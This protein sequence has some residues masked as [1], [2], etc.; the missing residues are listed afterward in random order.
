MPQYDPVIDVNGVPRT[1]RQF[2]CRLEPGLD[3]EDNV[4]FYAG[5]PDYLSHQPKAE[6]PESHHPHKAAE[7]KWFMGIDDV[8]PGCEECHATPDEVIEG[9]L[10]ECQSCNAILCL[11]CHHEHFIDHGI[12][13]Y[14]DEEQ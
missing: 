3:F 8:R 2:D 11:F 9:I 6:C 14:I 10:I 4:T 1:F 5:A 7:C 13:I 12:S